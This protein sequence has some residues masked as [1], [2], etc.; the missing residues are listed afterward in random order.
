MLKQFPYYSE[1]FKPD[2]HLRVK[3]L[4]FHKASTPDVDNSAKGAEIFSNL[5]FGNERTLCDSELEAV[6]SVEVALK[7]Q[8]LHPH[9]PLDLICSLL[10]FL[11]FIRLMVVAQL[12][13]TD[14]L[15]LA[16]F[17]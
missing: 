14:Y 7:P 10:F 5:S 1:F 3:A 2:K 16:L 4:L 13:T 9:P 12:V 6:Q 15:K 11:L 17:P 8:G